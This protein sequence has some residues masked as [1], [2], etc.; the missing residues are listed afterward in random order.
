MPDVTR[1]ARAIS[2]FVLATIFVLPS[3]CGESPLE[4]GPIEGALFL[5]GA[6][7]EE[8]RALIQDPDVIDQAEAL[9]GANKQMVILGSLRRGTGGF[10][11]PWSWH[12]APD[13]VEFADATIELCDGCPSF[14]EDDLDDWVDTVG[15]YCPWST[16]VLGRLH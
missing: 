1:S 5:I 3:G 2:A 9:I 10:N 13:T 6:C 16:R 8:F 4:P 12:L 11:S 7:E 14:V 15:T